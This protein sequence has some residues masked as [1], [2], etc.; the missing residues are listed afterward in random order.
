MKNNWIL[1]SV[2]KFMKHQS[3]LLILSFS[4]FFIVVP[5]LAQDLKSFSKQSNELNKKA[6]AA[7]L[8]GKS[9]IGLE[10]LVEAHRISPKNQDVLFNLAGL[11]LKN[12]E[13]KKSLELLE[14]A[15]H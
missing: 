11:Y 9:E 10:H 7:I 8:K 3:K 12:G 14:K 5:A 6:V 2:N 1:V 13:H 4:I 15:I